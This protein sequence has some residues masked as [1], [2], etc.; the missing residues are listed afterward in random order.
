[1]DINLVD[2]GLPNG[3]LWADRNV[4]AHSPEDLS[5]IHI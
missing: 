5:L 2:L 4:G 1:M 3:I